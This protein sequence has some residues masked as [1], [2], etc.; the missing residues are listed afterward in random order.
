MPTSQ[1]IGQLAA[2][3]PQA[4]NAAPGLRTCAVPNGMSR[5]SPGRRQTWVAVTYQCCGGGFT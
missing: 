1:K 2:G 4:V 3:V 5:V